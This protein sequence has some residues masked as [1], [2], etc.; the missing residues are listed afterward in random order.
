MVRGACIAKAGK[1]WDTG[2]MAS[3][4]NAARCVPW[5]RLPLA[6]LRRQPLAVASGQRR[7]SVAGSVRHGGVQHEGDDDDCVDPFALT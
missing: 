5:P 3:E 7:V 6:D 1:C 2:R 4:C